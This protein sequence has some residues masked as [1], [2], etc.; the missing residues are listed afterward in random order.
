MTRQARRTPKKYLTLTL[1]MSL[2]AGAGWAGYRL[3]DQH[4]QLSSEQ[5]ASYAFHFPNGNTYTYAL[6]WKAEQTNRLVTVQQ[7]SAKADVTNVSGKVALAG[8]LVLRSYGKSGDAYVLGLSLSDF[9]E[10]MWQVLGEDVVKETAR[11]DVFEGREAFLELAPSGQIRR[12]YFPSDTPPEFR[13]LVQWLVPELQFT[14]PDSKQAL[15]EGHWSRP[16]DTAHGRALSSYRI[17][18]TSPLS[19]SRTRPSYQSLS[20]GEVKDLTVKSDDQARARCA[21][22]GHLEQV[23]HTQQLDVAQKGEALLG[24]SDHF[25]LELE[26]VSSGPARTPVNLLSV[27]LQGFALNESPGS[28]AAAQQALV[29]QVGALTSGQMVS[30]VLEFAN[31]GRMDKKWL[32]QAAG[33]LQLHPEACA[34]LAAIFENEDL[35]RTGRGLI[36]D[37]LASAG[38]AEAQKVL[39]ELLE[40]PTAK[41]D[42]TD[43]AVLFNRVALVNDANTE[44]AEFVADQFDTLK[45][46]P[47][48]PMRVASAYALGAVAGHQYEQGNKAMAK[49]L[50]GRLV[51]DLDG[52]K[53]LGEKAVMLRAMGNAGLEENVD[54]LS[55]YTKHESPGL[56]AAAADALRDTHTNKS[57]EALLGLLQDPEWRVQESALS[58][59]AAYTL[60]PDEGRAIERLI[61]AGVVQSFNDPLLV[62]VLSRSANPDNPL[63]AGFTWVLGRNMQN[64]QLAARI[65]A[66]GRRNGVVL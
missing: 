27:N 59:L 14:L 13:G 11:K 9:R 18:H 58:S 45:E 33:L 52:T 43:H 54:T 34:E 42:E 53:D 29:N 63:A 28:D 41:A 60:S 23:E 44:T 4:G 21:D 26:Q 62:T 55:E 1:S 38:T 10:F 20:L 16:E 40:S 51:E 31:G 37:L 17:E 19:L 15:S 66:I 65:R 49:E 48:G 7:Q 30:D 35:T 2:L 64:G 61:V 8:K 57:V 32:W 3:L 47:L 5:L 39:R 25:S 50:N 12:T 6:Q 22:A 56:R 24:F 36:M 46:K